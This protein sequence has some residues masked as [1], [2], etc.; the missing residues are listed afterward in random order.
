MELFCD[1][2][3]IAVNRELISEKCEKGKWLSVD[4]ETKLGAGKLLAASEEDYPAPV[5]L[6][7]NLTGWYKLYIGLFNMRG[8]NVIYT[9]LSDDKEYGILRHTGLGCP[10]H[11]CKTEYMEEV[12]WRCADL[13]GQR[14][15]L[16]KPKLYIPTVSGLAWIRCEEMSEEEVARY[17]ACLEKP[18]KCVQMHYDV[19][20]FFED[21]SQEKTKHFAEISM[22]KNTSTDFVSVEYCLLYDNET[23]EP[24][25]PMRRSELSLRTGKFKDTDAILRE[26]VKWGKENGIPLYATE[27]MSM[28]NFAAP[29][30]FSNLRK[31]FVAN[32]PQYYCRTRDGRTVNACSYAYEAVWDYVIANMLRMVEMGFDGISMI[33]HRGVH[34]AFEQ[35]VLDRFAEL[36]PEIDPR[37]L[38]ITD[39][40]LNGVW[41]EFITGFLRRLRA[42]LDAAFDKHIP[43]NAIT[44]Y[45]IEMARRV[46]L[47]LVTWAKEG[48]VDS[49]SQGDMEI[50]ED[51]TDCMSDSDSSLIDLEKYSNRL[52]DCP[53]IRRSSGHIEKT[54]EY[55]QEFLAL[56][57]AYGVKVYNIL[58]WVECIP[59]GDYKVWV[60]KMQQLGAKRFLSY[61]T[62]HIA[63]VLPEFHVVS[64]LGND[65]GVEATL[66]KYY[67]V[68]SFGG[69]DISQYNANWR[70]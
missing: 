1:L 62:N 52:K 40:R 8:D 4:Y 68:L 64:S 21:Q 54:C 18:N 57:E 46:G 22:L 5:V 65:P 59:V 9:K 66:Q 32:H 50:Y 51:L 28:A 12:Y 17:K 38:P 15:I 60:E 29:Y 6:D 31:R 53:V 36:Y 14:L 37:Q 47:D 16:A 26:Y 20:A 56:E 10:K 2:A 48:L 44:A 39:R 13:T 55:I 43:V 23:D 7:L 30:F 34:I 67:R 41:C 49:I 58:P 11:W 35:P 33:M 70:G 69:S 45:S 3:K 24:Y 25:F 61:N 27:R 63:C 19:D 42:K